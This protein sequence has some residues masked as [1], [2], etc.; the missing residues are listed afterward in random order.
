MRLVSDHEVDDLAPLAGLVG[1]LRSLE[2][3]LP[4]WT[5]ETHLGASWSSSCHRHCPHAAWSETV[6]T[7]H[8][9]AGRHARLGDRPIPQSG[10]SRTR[11]ARVHDSAR[12]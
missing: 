11:K 12:V 2:G 8:A 1:R 3:S 10:S 9:A 4:P 5:T 7:S 6:L